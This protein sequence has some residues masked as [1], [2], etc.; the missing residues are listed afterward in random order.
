MW[1][2]WFQLWDKINMEKY[3]DEKLYRRNIMFCVK[4]GNECKEGAKFC[5]SCGAPIQR[6]TSQVSNVNQQAQQMDGGVQNQPQMWNVNMSQQGM[7]MP[8]ANRRTAP[9]PEEKTGVNKAAMIVAI[10]SFAGL[11]LAVCIAVFVIIPKMQQNQYYEQAVADYQSKQYL[12]AA[13]EF[14]ELGDYKDS[15][16]KLA[17]AKKKYF[18]EQ[19]AQ[20]EDVLYEKRDWEAA[21]NVIDEIENSR[22]YSVSE[23]M[24]KYEEDVELLQSV[25]DAVDME[26]YESATESLKKMNQKGTI[27]D[28]TE[29]CKERLQEQKENSYD[30]YDYDEDYNEEEDAE[31]DEYVIYDSNVRKLKKS[32]IKA[33]S[34]S[35]LRIAIN[36]LYARHGMQFETDEMRAHFNGCDWY[37]SEG[38]TAEEAESEFSDIEIYNKNLMAKERERRN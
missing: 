21:Q 34:D 32:E 27:S 22:Y 30:Y 6:S 25:Q 10:S 16:E 29:E 36:E 7:S 5:T 11:L 18:E 33:L 3:E 20:L 2:K 38:Y 13:E 12:V 24:V 17:Y 14:E 1:D 26:D 8:Q 37:M 31:S 35:Q 19:Y 4:C 9:A 23:Q 28:Y 15:Q